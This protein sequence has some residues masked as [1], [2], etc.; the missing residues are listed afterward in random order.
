MDS[1]P[2]SQLRHEVKFLVTYRQQVALLEEL[3][4]HLQPDAYGDAAGRYLVTSLYYDT[5]DR[6][7][8]WD[9]VNGYSLRRK[10]RARVYGDQ[11]VLPATPA[12]LEIKERVGVRM[13]KR[14]LRLSY[15]DAV[16]FETYVAEAEASSPLTQAP[17]ADEQRTDEQRTDEQRTTDELHYLF[18]ALRLQPTCVISY[19]RAAW[20]GHAY[21]PDLRVTFDTNLRCRIDNLSFL[22][23]D[24]GSIHT[25][26]PPGWAIL[27]IKVNQSMPFW[28]GE[29]LSRHGCTPRRVSKYCASLERCAA[30]RQRQHI[31][32]G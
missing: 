20:G 2:K 22:S 23:A 19:Q 31:L 7:A 12:Y 18:A 5:P 3:R 4:P 28:L 24:Q 32:L 21:Y 6:K 10:V 26:L 25:L 16:D 13:A 11:P 8:Y 30:I 9:K 14:R 17:P 1:R 15:A 27:E 29:I